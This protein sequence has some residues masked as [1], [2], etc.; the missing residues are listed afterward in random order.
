M[1][2]IKFVTTTAILNSPDTWKLLYNPWVKKGGG[3]VRYI[4]TRNNENR[5]YI[6]I[7]LMK[8]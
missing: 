4:L 3:K 7:W 1:A 2:K 5:T 8:L 6:N